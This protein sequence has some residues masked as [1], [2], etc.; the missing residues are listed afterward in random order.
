MVLSILVFN[1]GK[2]SIIP[3]SLILAAASG[4]TTIPQSTAAYTFSMIGALFSTLKS[5]TSA[6]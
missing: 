4:F 3:P 1:R 6:T 2:N 5:M